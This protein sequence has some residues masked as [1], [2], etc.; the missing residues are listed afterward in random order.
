MAGALVEYA[1]DFQPV[2][3]KRQQRLQ[4][5]DRFAVIA[6]G[7]E[8][9]AVNGVRLD[10][11]A[12]T[13]A[14]KAGPGKGLAGIALA[15]GGDVGMGEQPMGGN[16]AAADNITAEIDHRVD[17]GAGKCRQA[18]VMAAIGDLDADGA[19]I[20]VALTGPAGGAGVPGAAILIDHLDDAAVLKDK[21]VSGDLALL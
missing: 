17:L 20:D 16:G 15:P 11:M 1:A 3:I 21:I 9:A 14:G 13:F 12:D 2:A 7:Q 8:A 19:G 4:R 18:A 6:G 10:P 5:R